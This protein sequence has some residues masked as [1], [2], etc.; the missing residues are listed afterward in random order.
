VR[1]TDL[2]TGYLAELEA[3]LPA[4]IV[5]ELED[6]LEE[7]FARYRKS[8]LDGDTAA[9][10]AIAEFGDP[11]LVAAGFAAACPARRLARRLLVTGPAVGL[12]WGALL[13]MSR[14]WTWPLPDPARAAVGTGLLA[15]IAMLARA[16]LADSYRAITRAAA[17]GCASITVLDVTMIIVAFGL[18]L[19][20]SWLVAIAVT[21]SGL[22]IV[23]IIQG[24]PRLRVGR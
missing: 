11:Q 2:I 6:G 24:L 7:A 12:C 16:A 1:R 19:R 23:H 14:A 21:A 17:A 9:R 3:R 20:P 15:A 8:G 18:T 22:R 5:E 10:A 4:L 13:I